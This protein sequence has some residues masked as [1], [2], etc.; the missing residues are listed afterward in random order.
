MTVRLIVPRVAVI[1]L[2]GFVVVLMPRVMMMRV[3]A[4][5]VCRARRR[6]M[7]IGVV[8]GARHQLDVR[9]A[10]VRAEHFSGLQLVS[11]SEAAQRLLQSVE[12]QPGIEK[13]AEHHVACRARKTIEVHHPRHESHP[14]S[15]IEQ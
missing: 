2:V 9:R 3:V 5:V 14:D 8:A 15:F 1:V 12:R 7:M 11:D 10:D 13:R 4:M 6:V